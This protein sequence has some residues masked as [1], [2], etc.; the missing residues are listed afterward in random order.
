M[1]EHRFGGPP[2]YQNITN[3]LPARDRPERNRVPV[4]ARI[5]WEQDGEQWVGGHALRLDME[6]NAIFVEFIDRRHRFTGAWLAP[7]DVEWDGKP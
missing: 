2:E 1:Y 5:V 4:R 6:G 3:A 7:D